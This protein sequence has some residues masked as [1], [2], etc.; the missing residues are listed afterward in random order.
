VLHLLRFEL[1]ERAFW[2]GLKDYT[3]THEGGS[4]TTDDL[5]TA[6]ERAGGRNLSAFFE[7]WIYGAEAPALEARHRVEGREVVV[8]IEQKQKALWPVPLRVAVET[9]RGRAARTF[10][11]K[12]RRQEF[13]LPV[14]GV[15]L[16][17]R[18]DDGGHLPVRVAH[19]RTAAMLLHQLARE[20]DPA[21]RLDALEQL[22]KLCGDKTT[23]ETACESLSSALA[24]RAAKDS[25]RLVRERARKAPAPARP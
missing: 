16:S 10:V 9:S 2:Q 8:T 14:Q 5:Q 1:G 17:V 11:L 3:R 19:E 12:E 13:R 22:Q 20:P 4:V 7:H 15:P 23:R 6:M 21:G 24:E 25:S 18:L